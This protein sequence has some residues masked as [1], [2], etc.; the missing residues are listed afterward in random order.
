MRRLI[1]GVVTVG[2][3]LAGCAVASNPGVSYKDGEQYA[4]GQVQQGNP[5]VGNAQTACSVFAADGQVPNLDDK[6]TWEKGC[7]AGL[8]NATFLP[9]GPG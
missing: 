3:V 7:Q 2:T 4:Q 8:A 9:T 5:I 6:G 1:L